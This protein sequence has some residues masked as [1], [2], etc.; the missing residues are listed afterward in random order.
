MK[1]GNPAGEK[2]SMV[3][4]RLEFSVGHREHSSDSRVNPG[5]GVDFGFGFHDRRVKPGFKRRRI[6]TF[7]DLST[8]IHRQQRLFC[9]H[10]ETHP[11]CHK[12]SVRVR[13]ASTHMT[14]PLDES[15]M[16]QDSARADDVLSELLN[17]GFHKA[18]LNFI[19]FALYLCCSDPRASINM[20]IK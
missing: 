4:H 3:M 20:K 11:R 19:E 6:P 16:G 17:R 14:K 5:D 10:C 9:D 12:K 18:P 13:D 1:N 8:E 2:A 7:D 15:L